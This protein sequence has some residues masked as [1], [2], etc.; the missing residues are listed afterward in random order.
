VN[1]KYVKVRKKMTQNPNTNTKARSTMF[2]KIA[3]ILL[4]AA[5]ITGLIFVAVSGPIA[6][7]DTKNALTLPGGSQY[8][9]LPT[10]ASDQS[11][12]DIAIAAIQKAAG[13]FKIL[14]GV[15]AIFLVIF[16]GAKLV[17]SGGDEE[18]VKKTTTGFTYSLIAFAIISLAE[19]IAQIVGFFDEGSTFGG[20]AN[21]GIIG[22]PGEILER[23]HLFDKQVE[24]VITFIKYLIGSI[25]VLM[26]V[27]NGIKLVV[28]GGE[29]E[30][31]KKARN[32]VI[33]S[34]FG[35]VLLFLGN[36]FVNNVF[37]KL[38]KNMYTGMEGVAP[39]TDLQQG[40][41]ELVGIT[42]F[43][44]SFVGP[45]LLLLLLIGGV[46]YMTAGGEEEK[47]NKAKRLIVAALIGVIVV[48]GAF[49]IISTVVSGYFQSPVT[50]TITGV[51]GAQT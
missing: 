47:M 24:I 1:N 51:T 19:E 26:I 30:N 29:E 4:E 44:V 11:G 49:A 10:P 23:V 6:L 39:Q 48:F 15:V 45:L 25:A 41:N 12:Q 21:G 35:L 34:L 36:I 28:G 50:E 40:M 42:N 27:V 46:M 9:G 17:L 22:S 18:G 37:Y 32:G 13:Y 7:A 16:M 31:V 33:Y 43:I 3:K 38:D 5:I 8:T 14:I 20:K 2:K